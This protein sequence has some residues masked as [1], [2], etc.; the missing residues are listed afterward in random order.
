MQENSGCTMQISAVLPHGL[1]HE[2]EA[3]RRQ[4]YFAPTGILA[5]SAAQAAIL[6]GNGWPVV[7]SHLCFSTVRLFWRHKGEVITALAPFNTVLDWSES[8]GSPLAEMA[9]HALQAIGKKRRPFAGLELDRPLIMGIVNVT[10]DSFSDG[11]SSAT[12][13]QAI[14][15]AR[16]ML[17]EGADI[18]DIGGESTRPGAEPVSTDEEIRRILPVI[19]ELAGQGAVVSVDTRHAAVMEAALQ[20]G[21]RI[22]NDISA[23]ED[24]PAALDVVVRHQASVVLM[25]KQGDPQTMQESPHYESVVLD[26]F[27]YLRDRLDV[28]LKAGLPM[29]SLCVDPG[30]GFGKNVSHN[31]ALLAHLGLYH[32]LGCP[33]LLGASRK[34]FIAEI[35]GQTGNPQQRL[36]GS[37][38]AVLAG[39]DRG[40]QIMR[41]HD[42]AETRQAIDVWQAIRSAE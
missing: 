42:V 26:I 39:L 36:P 30:I 33:I 6:G 17:E 14:A 7:D 34:R 22:I 3:L 18:L 13:E 23:L 10:P 1:W 40:V 29:E 20:A 16:R 9:A 28:C 38:T 41:V 15:K 27:D 5:G 8:E 35:S 25:H 11:G 4:V 12:H 32:A 24:D 21:A 31:L 2:G 37:L 19:R